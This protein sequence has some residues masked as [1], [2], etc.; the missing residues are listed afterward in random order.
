MDDEW[1]MMLIAQFRSYFPC[2]L[3]DQYRAMLL[4]VTLIV[5]YCSDVVICAN[6]GSMKWLKVLVPVV[7]NTAGICL[8]AA[9]LALLWCLMQS[10]IGLIVWTSVIMLRIV[11]SYDIICE[12]ICTVSCIRFILVPYCLIIGCFDGSI[13]YISSRWSGMKD[14]AIFWISQGH[15]HCCKW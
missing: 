3:P 11:P 14:W 9:L 5:Y 12:C 13:S 15:G 8:G 2:L 7:C 10:I 6:T 1:T 4:L